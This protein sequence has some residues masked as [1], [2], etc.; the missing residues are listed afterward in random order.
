MSIF[1]VIEKKNQTAYQ[2]QFSSF[3]EDGIFKNIWK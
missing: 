1:I 2:K 3:Y